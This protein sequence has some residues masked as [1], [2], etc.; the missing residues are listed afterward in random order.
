MALLISNTKNNFLPEPKTDTT[1]QQGKKF[2]P[3]HMQRVLIP[4][5]L[6]VNTLLLHI[7]L[8]ALNDRWTDRGRILS[9]RVGWRNFFPVVLLCQFFG[10]GE[11]WFLV[12]LPYLEYNT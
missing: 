6:L 7:P 11:K 5:F 12:L 1:A 10:C 9:L 8:L 4:T 2:P 3:A